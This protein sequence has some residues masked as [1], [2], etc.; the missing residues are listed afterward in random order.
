MNRKHFLSLISAA[1]AGIVAHRCGKG[2]NTLR[3]VLPERGICAHRGAMDTHPENTLAAFREAIDAG[4]HMIELDA[5]LTKDS[6][7]VVIHDK[8]VDRTTDGTGN[9]SDL[10]L[11]EIQKLD[12]GSWKSPDFKGERIPSLQEALGI[13]PSNI[14][15][16]VH[17]K[18]GKALGEKAARMIVRENRQHQAFLACGKEAAAGARAII[19]GILVCNM[20]R[21]KSSWDYVNETIAMKADFIQLLKPITPELPEYT[22]K[23]TENGVRIN[24]FGTDSPD[25]LYELFNAGVQFPLVNSIVQTMQAVKKMGIYPVKPEFDF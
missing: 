11:A 25:E 7:L 13:M 19:P 12:A 9:V 3:A 8:T 5:Y 18:G 6:H 21:Q 15:L 24:Y 4:A 14:W 10:T 20:E 2:G 23:L 17:L 1:C 16:N 22:S